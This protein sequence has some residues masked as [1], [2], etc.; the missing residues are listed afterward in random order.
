ML[1]CFKYSVINKIKQRH[2]NEIY[3]K[4]HILVEKRISKLSSKLLNESDEI[5]C[6]QHNKRRDNY[7]SIHKKS[8]C[9]LGQFLAKKL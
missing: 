9:V 8:V 4:M 6:T 2:F 5:N 7:E 1:L 3:S